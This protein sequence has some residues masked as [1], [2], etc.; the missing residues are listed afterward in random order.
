MR[1]DTAPCTND[2]RDARM[3]HPATEMGFAEL[4]DGLL[5]ALDAKLVTRQHSGDG[6]ET[7]CYSNSC[8]YDR[9]WNPITLCARG[10]ILDAEAGSIAALPFPKFFNVGENLSATVPDLP[11]ET[12]EK[13]DGSL[14]IMFWHKGEWRTA[15]KGAFG[16]DQAKWA[17]AWIAGQDLSTLDKGVTYLAEAIY[18]EN[19][20]VVAYDR[21]E[22][23]LLAAYRLDGIEL[24]Y[25][26]LRTVG[27]RLGWTVAKRHSFASVTDLILHTKG[28]PPSEEGFVLRFENGVRLKVK[29]EEYRRIHALISKLS[30]LSI[31]DAM[32][33]GDDMEAIRRD[34]PEEFWDDFDAMRKILN[35][36]VAKII[37]AT[38]AEAERL[39]DLSDK[40]IGLQLKSF[41]EPV[42]SFIFPYRKQGGNLLTGR[43]RDALFRS[44]RPTGNRLDGYVPSYLLNRV[45]EESQ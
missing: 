43:S 35:H 42:R 15:T 38:K 9:Q 34:L 28:L 18:P 6:L 14:I 17:K 20:I 36:Q 10:L 21:S 1:F 11:F 22:L 24:R 40:D 16:S 3:K 31:W 4:R 7:Y 5:A 29:G 23:V 12:F 30:P 44:I 32:Q 19:R 8:V 26:E 39:A 45:M 25:D 13:L 33:A 27:E 37:R 41:P 2:T